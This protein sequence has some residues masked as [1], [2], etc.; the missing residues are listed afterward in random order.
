MFETSENML[1]CIAWALIIVLIIY[2]VWQILKPRLCMF[3]KQGLTVAPANLEVNAPGIKVASVDMKGD[4][5][6][7]AYLKEQALEPAVEEQHR[8]WHGEIPHT[9]TTSS[10]DV[11]LDSDDD[12]N[13]R[14]GL[15]RIDYHQV[16]P[17][18][19]D[20]RTMP[21]EEPSQMPRVKQFCI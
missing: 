1:S 2:L 14:W 5:S 21:S 20:V 16:W 10:H 11:V 18:A 6:F 8:K 19:P 15:R 12:I 17:D 4:D 13:P 3:N 9:T 7:N